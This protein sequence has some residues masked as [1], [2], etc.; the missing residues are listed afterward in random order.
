MSRRASRRVDL[1][2]GIRPKLRAARA[3]TRPR[4]VKRLQLPQPSLRLA[5]P[6]THRAPPEAVSAGL[7]SVP[8]PAARSRSSLR[9]RTAGPPTWEHRLR[10]ARPSPRL[11]P[12]SPLPTPPHSRPVARRNRGQRDLQLTQSG[13]SSPIC[14]YQVVSQRRCYR[15]NGSD[16]ARLEEQSPHVAL[17]LVGCLWWNGGRRDPPRKDVHPQ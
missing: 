17:P 16:V 9:A 14:P 11:L 3:T 4:G 1:L 2:H 13:A 10:L 5:P 12:F 15:S 7:D 8:A 6:T